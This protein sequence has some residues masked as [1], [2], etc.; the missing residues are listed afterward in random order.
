[1]AWIILAGVVAVVLP[2]VVASYRA[3][4]RSASLRRRFGPEYERLLARGGDRRSVEGHLRDLVKRREGLDIHD[5]DIDEL[6]RFRQRWHDLQLS[7]VDDPAAS[8]EAAE[9]LLAEVIAARGYPAGSL[10]QRLALLSVDH[11][12]LIESYR[13]AVTS[14]RRDIDDLRTAFRKYRTVFDELAG[15]GVRRPLRLVHSTKGRA[16]EDQGRT[17]R[18]ASAGA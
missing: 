10:S 2:I 7:F 4:S 14:P 12:R 15:D 11:P 5:P 1:M 18:Q 9:A 17:N 16:R 6:S 13:T 3:R 8:V